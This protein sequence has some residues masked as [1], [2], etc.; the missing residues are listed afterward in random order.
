[1]LYRLSSPLSYQ[2]IHGVVKWTGASIAT[3]HNPVPSP[4]N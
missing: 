1:M 4:K 3:G 2:G